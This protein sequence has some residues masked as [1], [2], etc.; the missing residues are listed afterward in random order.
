M[1]ECVCTK[2]SFDIKT[3]HCF[4]LL[5]HE[6]Q[7]IVLWCSYNRNIS[8]ESL[9]LLLLIVVDAFESLPRLLPFIFV[10]T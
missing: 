8:F 5:Q 10:Q 7:V 1:P 3:H 2:A 6:M 9:A 4:Y